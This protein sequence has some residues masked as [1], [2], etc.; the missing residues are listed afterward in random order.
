M[1]AQVRSLPARERLALQAM[2]DVW[3][4]DAQLFAELAAQ[5]K[6]ISEDERGVFNRKTF[7]YLSDGGQSFTMESVA[8]AL[9]P[10]I[11]EDNEMREVTVAWVKEHFPTVAEDWRSKGFEQGIEQGIEQGERRA[12]RKLARKLM[13]DG[14]SEADIRRLTGLSSKELSQLKNGG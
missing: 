7:D 12:T 8:V 1:R 5:S 10:I 9:E 2:A 3:D 11:A 14:M 4:A 13:S 6:A